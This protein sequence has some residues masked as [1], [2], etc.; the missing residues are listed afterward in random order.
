L[1]ARRNT[2]RQ[3]KSGLKMR[4]VFHWAVHRIHA[5]V[6]LTVLSLL[7]ERLAEQACGDTWRNIRDDL[8]Q[9]KVAQLLGQNGTL[10]QVTEPRDA[11]R[12]R[13]KSL[14]INNLPTILEHL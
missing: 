3:L 11:A 5:H 13:L 14:G 1:G 12:N 6:F 8:K 2:W 10:W 9:I 7:L 4:P